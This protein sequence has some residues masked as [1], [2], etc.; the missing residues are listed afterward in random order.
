VI[1]VLRAPPQPVL[2]PTGLIEG[3]GPSRMMNY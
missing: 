3:Q 2:G 1:L